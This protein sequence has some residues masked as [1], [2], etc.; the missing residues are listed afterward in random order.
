MKPEA[1]SKEQAIEQS[2][3]PADSSSRAALFWELTKPRLTFLVMVTTFV[4]F[5]MAS[6]EEFDVI[7]FIHTMAG[8]A[9]VAAG[10]AV[11]NQ[12]LERDV[13]A[14]MNR[15]KG[16]PIPSGK[17]QPGEALLFGVILSIFGLFYLMLCVNLLS[18]FLAVLTIGS[19]LFL[20]TPLKKVSPVCTI[21][22]AFPGALPPLIG[23]TGARN[24]VDYGGWVL[25]AILFLWQMPHFYALARMYRDD[26]ARGGFPM[27]TVVD[28]RG[29][30]TGVQILF[31][32]SLLVPVSLLPSLLPAHLKLTGPV[33]F[34]GALVL[35]LGFLWFAIRASFSKDIPRSKHLFLASIVYLP[36]LLILMV[37]D[38][39]S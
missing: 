35:S 30:R 9:F 1:S 34:W 3:F 17:L 37:V 7:L 12:F 15:T 18:S 24:S 2:D 13:D 6:R 39:V 32:A 16:R 38:K 5:C 11:L 8:T 23:W 20:Y 27:L 26:Y 19:Y 25:F 33:Y 4:G 29:I 36:V 22:G 28:D 14:N 21:I 31:H 10:A